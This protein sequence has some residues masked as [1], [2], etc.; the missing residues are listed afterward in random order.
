MNQYHRLL[1]SNRGLGEFKARPM[2]DDSATIY[3]YD[4]IVG[5]DLEAD[6]FGGVGPE[7]F[8]RTVAGV[9]A[10]TLNLRVNSPGG[11]VFAARTMA[12]ALKDFPGKVVAHVDGLAAS[13]ASFL[14]MAADE[15][16]MAEGS[17]IM[18][19]NAWSIAL[20]N[21]DGLRQEA[22]LLDSIDNSLVKT[23]AKR[24]GMGKEEIMSMMNAETWLDSDEAVAKGFANST[25]D[26]E[27]QNAKHWDL[28]AY[29]NAPS[30]QA[31]AEASEADDEDE[32]PEETIGQINEHD[33]RKR[34]IDLARR[35][36]LTR[37]TD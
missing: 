12:Q 35:A 33:M 16:V 5:N 4:A 11:S 6:L 7:Q 15:I 31:Q 28:S 30:T 2:G 21:A 32:T 8:A 13:A 27:I 18:I 14:I 23:Y 34:R 25:V 26:S 10:A 29:K 19:H 17:F 9:K 36:L 1:I 20:G 37:L 24:T 3:L 22:D